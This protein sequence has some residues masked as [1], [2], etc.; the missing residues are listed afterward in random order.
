MIPWFAIARDAARLA[1]DSQAVMAMRLVRF[2]RSA[3]FDWMEAQR[4]TSEK[5]HA[6][7]QVQLALL[8]GQHGRA[9]ARKTISVYGT[10]VRANRRRL[11]R[12]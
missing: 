4:M 5:V 9:L 8:S 3:K 6:L 1:M 2:A 11:S 12:G 10:R 7:A